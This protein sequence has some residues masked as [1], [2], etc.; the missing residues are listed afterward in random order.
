MTQFPLRFCL[1]GQ[2]MAFP[3]VLS[4][5]VASGSRMGTSADC[6]ENHSGSSMATETTNDTLSGLASPQLALPLSQRLRLIAYAS[7]FTTSADCSLRI[8]AVLDTPDAVRHVR[9]TEKQLDGQMLG[10]I[11]PKQMTFKNNGGGLVFRMQE[12]SPHW[13]TRLSFQ[14]SWTTYGFFVSLQTFECFKPH[15]SLLFP[16]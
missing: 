4:P 14:V 7:R 10:G 6:S 12:M 11:T 13:R 8:Y 1:V 16:S 9:D 3:S 5:T 15:P 2:P